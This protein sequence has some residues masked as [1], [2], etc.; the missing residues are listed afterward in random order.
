M[1]ISDHQ[2]IE[3]N[4][5]HVNYKYSQSY[6]KYR[7]SSIPCNWNILYSNHNMLTAEKRLIANLWV[8]LMTTAVTKPCHS[9]QC[10]SM[11]R[12]IWAIIS[13]KHI[14]R[15]ESSL[16]EGAADLIL[17]SCSEL[18][19]DQY[20]LYKG[21][22]LSVTAPPLTSLLQA[23]RSPLS[24]PLFRKHFINEQQ[25]FSG[26]GFPFSHSIHLDCYRDGWM[27]VE[28]L[29]YEGWVES[30]IVPLVLS[31]SLQPLFQH[32]GHVHSSGRRCAEGLISWTLKRSWLLHLGSSTLLVLPG[33]DS[34]S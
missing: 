3:L 8:V 13:L 30:N 33:V 24:G 17:D 4:T 9:C 14:H 27:G 6:P 28:N 31:G 22:D 12:R 32:V 1:N 10:V 15:T 34:L 21:S 23:W 29:D 18:L 2:L 20:G 16:G 11:W 19:L 7:P 26:N 25:G 5:M